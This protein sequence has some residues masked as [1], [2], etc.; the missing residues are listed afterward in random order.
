MDTL[1]WARATAPSLLGIPGYL[2]D[3]YKMDVCVMEA[4]ICRR[5]WL[6]GSSGMSS[7]MPG[8]QANHLHQ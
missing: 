4:L 3:E 2:M 6:L 5:S 1:W 7:D 8:A